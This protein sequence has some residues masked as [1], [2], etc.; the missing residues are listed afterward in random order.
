MHFQFRYFRLFQVRQAKN[1]LTLC[2]DV[3]SFFDR[4]LPTKRVTSLIFNLQ[5]ITT[6]LIK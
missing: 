3:F 1:N 5:L 2:V 4:Q 6:K